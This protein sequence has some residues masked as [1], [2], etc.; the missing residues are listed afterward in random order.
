VT[1]R[2][3]L[4]AT[5]NKG[6]LVEAQKLADQYEITL[7][8]LD[9]LSSKLGAVP[10]VIEDLDSYY[11]NAHKKASS[12]FSWSNQPTLADDTGLEVEAL[13]GAPG[14][15]SARYAGENASAR[16]NSDKL[17]HALEGKTNRKAKFICTLVFIDADS[18][19]SSVNAELKGEIADSPSGT[20]GFGYDSIF[21]IPELKMTLSE[22]KENGMAVETHRIKALKELLANLNQSPSS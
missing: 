5:T 17:L 11:G 6:K 7:Y 12:Y 4:F 14:V 22:A 1:R 9:Q 18:T 20:G 3:L 10:E 19:I 13:L 2:S 21:Y 15:L 16:A 8:S